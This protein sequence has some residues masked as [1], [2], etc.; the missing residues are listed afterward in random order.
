MKRTAYLGNNKSSSP[1]LSPYQTLYIRPYLI[2]QTTPVVTAVILQ[3]SVQVVPRL[4]GP[5]KRRALDLCRSP[6][7]DTAA[8]SAATPAATP[9]RTWRARG[10]RHNS[11]PPRVPARYSRAPGQ[12]GPPG[13]AGREPDF[14]GGASGGQLAT[15]PSPLPGPLPSSPRRPAGRSERGG[16]FQVLLVGAAAE[17][18]LPPAPGL[19]PAVRPLTHLQGLSLRSRPAPVPG[20]ALCR[21][22][23]TCSLRSPIPPW[24]RNKRWRLSKGG[25]I[26]HVQKPPE[27]HS[28]TTL[29]R[30]LDSNSVLDDI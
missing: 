26:A 21:T 6:R 27:P 23:D 25:G 19:A 1:L 2:Q 3:M 15:P 17:T 22:A 29:P 7:L 18:R 11:R 8:A 28:G 24:D 4:S 10:P 5:V 9:A 30:S 12:L 20:P 14:W 13:S 16:G